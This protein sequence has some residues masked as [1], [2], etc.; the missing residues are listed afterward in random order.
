MAAGRDSRQAARPVRLGLI[1]DNIGPS[2]SPRLHELCGELTGLAVSYELVVP[3]ERGLDFAAVFARCQ[4]DGMA[5]VNVTYPYKE[6]VL[7]LVRP[8][9]PD[10][11]RL[12]AVNTVVFGPGGPVGYNTDRSGFVAAFRVRFAD[13]MPGRVAIIGTGGVGRAISFA[14]AGLGA[15]ELRLFDAEAGKAAGLAAALGGAPGEMAVSVAGELAAALEDADGIVNC[16]PVG[17]QG[18]PGTPVPK[19]FLGRQ[20]WAFDAVYTPSETEFLR[21]AGQAGLE[22]LSGY[23]LFFQQ[24]IEAFRCFTGRAPPDLEELRRRLL[25]GPAG[26][27]PPPLP[28]RTPSR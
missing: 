16:T 20:R 21:D 15:A 12:G 24:G 4:R 17:M 25:A 3:R 2:R 13:M 8:A 9:A 18:K 11:A 22:V 5:G 26:T 28:H 23:E 7:G 6:Q 14:L 10:I 27:T 19:R 1:G